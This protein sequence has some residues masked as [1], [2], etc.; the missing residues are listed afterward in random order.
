MAKPLSENRRAR[1]DYDIADIYE[2]GI[3]LKGFEVKSV[4]SGH[5]N[6]TGAYAIVRGGEVWLLNMEI[7]PYQP[8]NMPSDYDSTRTRRLLLKKEEIKVL[9]GKIKE[10]G[11]T[12]I[13]LKLYSKNRRIK[14]ALGL[15]KAKKKYDKREMIKKRETEREI[16]RHL[17]K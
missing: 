4:T 13:P 15:G 3:E 16:R 9:T 14:I 2:A 1:F 11:L 6:L 17:K 5:G 8:A 12:L 7:P 10:R